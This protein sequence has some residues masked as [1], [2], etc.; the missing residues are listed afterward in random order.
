MFWNVRETC[1]RPMAISVAAEKTVV[2][3]AKDIKGMNQ[4]QSGKFKTFCSMR[5]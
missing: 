5:L 4:Q 2:R 1:V 3:G